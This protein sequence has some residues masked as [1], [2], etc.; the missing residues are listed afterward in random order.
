VYRSE[1]KRQILQDQ[2]TI[3]EEDEDLLNDNNTYENGHE[4]SH[5]YNNG[6]DDNKNL[7]NG[8]DKITGV[9]NNKNALTIENVSTQKGVSEEKK[10]SEGSGYQ[11]S[12]ATSS[13]S[14]QNVSEQSMT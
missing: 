13:I 3:F 6:Q 12:S 5:C 2:S 10:T 4:N 11:F 8:D 7:V 1:S 14:I 9:E